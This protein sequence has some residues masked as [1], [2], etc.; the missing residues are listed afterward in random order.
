MMLGRIN[1]GRI[2]VRTVP[3]PRCVSGLD[4]RKGEKEM[5]YRKKEE[6]RR[7]GEVSLCIRST[8]RE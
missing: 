2:F 1:E 6:E 5:E 4:E 8:L 3:S 7:E